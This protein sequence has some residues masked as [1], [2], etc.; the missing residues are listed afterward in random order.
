MNVTWRSWIE[1][2]IK[3]TT[4]KKKKITKL[5]WLTNLRW[6]YPDSFKRSKC[7][8]SK[9]LPLTTTSSFWL[10]PEGSKKLPSNYNQQAVMSLILPPRGV[11]AMWAMTVE[12]PA[13]KRKLPPKHLTLLH[14]QSITH[15]CPVSQVTWP[16]L[17]CAFYIQRLWTPML[18]TQS[19]HTI[20]RM[21]IILILKIN[22]SVILIYSHYCYLYNTFFM[23]MKITF[24][25]R[26]QKY[27]HIK[28]RKHP[29]K[30]Y[31]CGCDYCYKNKII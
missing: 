3:G 31:G 1:F 19:V 9:K 15:H 6:H 2:L 21:L 11:R 24:V 14:D 5:P 20:L 8:Q 4:I 30:N 25:F 7:G 17:L 28:C 29:T 16:L 27:S 23:L 22:F 18:P 12:A 13:R 10:Q 26:K